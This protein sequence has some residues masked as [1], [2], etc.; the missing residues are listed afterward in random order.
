MGF[1][2]KYSIDSILMVHWIG[3]LWVWKIIKIIVI[4]YFTTAFLAGSHETERILREQ[5][6]ELV[7]TFR[8]LHWTHSGQW[9]CQ[10]LCDVSVC[11]PQAHTA[12]LEEIDTLQKSLSEANNS[13]IQIEVI[14]EVAYPCYLCTK[15][16]I[17]ND[18]LNVHIGTGKSDIRHREGKDRATN[19]HLINTIKMKLEIKA[20]KG[21]LE[22]IATR[23]IVAGIHSILGNLPQNC[24]HHHHSRKRKKK[25]L[26]LGCV[27]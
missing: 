13:I 24:H 22:C 3:G 8:R 20:A 25:E 9:H 4:T 10:V 27:V 21:A 11:Q 26:N 1:K 12:A 14:G 19:V 16:L 5:N 23:W 7:P 18:A 15:N 2:G 6:F 17:R